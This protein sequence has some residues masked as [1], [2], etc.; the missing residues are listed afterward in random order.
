MAWQ[1]NE[2]CN[3]NDERTAV[4]EF[5]ISGKHPSTWEAWT[6]TLGLRG[7]SFSHHS[8]QGLTAEQQ[9]KPEEKPRWSDLM[10]TLSQSL[11]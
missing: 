3:K 6:Q 8:V 1:R 10:L 9:T 5:A 4:S 11:R 7:D 2:F